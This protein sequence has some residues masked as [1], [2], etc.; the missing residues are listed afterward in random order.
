M[1]VCILFATRK[2]GFGF[3]MKNGA[4]INYKVEK[5][6]RNEQMSRRINE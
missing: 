4:K 6:N 1:I 2:N 3:E 5:L